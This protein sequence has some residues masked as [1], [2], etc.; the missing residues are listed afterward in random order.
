MSKTNKATKKASKTEFQIID[1]ID[2]VKVTENIDEMTKKSCEEE[3]NEKS[4]QDKEKQIYSKNIEDVSTS[5]DVEKNETCKIP[6][7][8]IETEKQESSLELG[9]F[10]HNSDK[11]SEKSE[12]ME[13]ES[14]EMR[15]SV[16]ADS[17][18]KD[19]VNVEY[20]RTS[21]EKLEIIKDIDQDSDEACLKKKGSL[22]RT[23]S[24][25]VKEE[26]E[27]IEKQIKALESR[28]EQEN[29]DDAHHDDLATSTKSSIQ[30]NRRH[31]FQD[32]MDGPLKLEFKKLPCEQK[33]I[34][35]VRLTD[36]S[37]PMAAPRDPVKVIELHI[38]E[39]IKCKP[40][41]LDEINPIP[42][43]RRH[44]ALC[45]KNHNE[46]KLS[47]NEIQ[48]AGNSSKDKRGQSV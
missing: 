5:D 47:R 20:E 38:S 9:S 13:E 33:D 35:V 24:F 2:I 42:K 28:K 15:S 10:S 30:V 48:N 37:T 8:C 41:L 22:S 40:E 14:K 1:T 3:L 23:N 29:I 34:H 31:F 16:T 43:P 26:I 21:Q 27:K 4:L 12:Q 39:P 32:I 6:E 46:A 36:T 7:D 44:S 11:S 19:S 17:I 25:S 18:E 45:L